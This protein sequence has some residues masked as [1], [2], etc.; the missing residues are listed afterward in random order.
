[1]EAATQVFA[2][3][4]FDSATTREVAE[5]AGCSEGLI[6]RYFGGKRGLLLAILADKAER[7]TELV[8]GQMPECETV[9]DEIAQML[10]QPLETYWQQREFMRVSVSQAAIDTDVGRMIGDRLNASKVIFF[11]ERLRTHQRAGRIRPDVDVTALSLS[12][13]G[14]NIACG[15]FAQVAFGMDRA[16]VRYCVEETAAVIA[17]GLAPDVAAVTG[18][19]PVI[20]ARAGRGAVAAAR[21]RGSAA[22]AESPST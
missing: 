3:K 8:A 16:H 22:G 1:M 4:G 11:A 6:H 21:K 13:S 14:M 20:V 15:F 17:R 9:A 18:D 2:E 5:R 7:M 19:A 10:A 12:L